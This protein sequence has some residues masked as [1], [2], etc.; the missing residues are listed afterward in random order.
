MGGG[1]STSQAFKGEMFK[2][3]VWNRVLSPTTISQMSR[4]CLHQ[5]TGNV[6]SWK[7]FQDGVKGNVQ[8]VDAIC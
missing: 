8:T 4:S 6:V 1:F 5:Q 2:V 7:E 3:N